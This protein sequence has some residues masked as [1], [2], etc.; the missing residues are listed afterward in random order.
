VQS[1]IFD[2]QPL[3]CSSFFSLRSH[4]PQPIMSP[5]QPRNDCLP[6]LPEAKLNMICC[7]LWHYEVTALVK[8]ASSG[9]LAPSLPTLHPQSSKRWQLQKT[10]PTLHS[11]QIEKSFG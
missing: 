9:G 3:C 6:L 2:W 5:E 7:I 4:H 11:G 10:K 8:L 1:V